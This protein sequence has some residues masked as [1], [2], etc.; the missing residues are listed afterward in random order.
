MQWLSKFV[1]DLLTVTT[2]VQV[3]EEQAYDSNL[4]FKEE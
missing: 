3:K 2:N 4:I 1:M